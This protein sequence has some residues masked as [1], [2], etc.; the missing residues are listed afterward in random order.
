MFGKLRSFLGGGDSTRSQDPDG[1]EVVE[2]EPFPR[3]RL[4]AVPAVPAEEEDEIASA[5]GALVDLFESRE[6]APPLLDPA[7]R[8][9]HEAS[10]RPNVDFR[11]LAAMLSKDPV[12]A[13]ELL[14]T[15]NSP[16]YGGSGSVDSLERAL[17]R[18]GI[19]GIR[20]ILFSVAA[21]RVLRVPG[22]SWFT[23]RLRARSRAVAIAARILAESV[24]ADSE[25]AYTAGVLHDVGW[26]VAYDL[27]ARPGPAIPEAL[28]RDPRRA[29]Q[30]A[31]RTHQPLGAAL[32]RRWK[33]P[34]PVIH[35]LGAHHH[36]GD[37]PGDTSAR[38]VGGARGI[39]DF[40][41]FYPEQQLASPLESP[42]LGE[43]GLSPQEIAAAT[44]MMR[45]EMVEGEESWVQASSPGRR[46]S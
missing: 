32:G 25:S 39:C 45:T 4:L 38:L 5:S 1:G 21:G 14:R 12:V 3:G 42:A 37:G 20:N 34:E 13:M 35:A 10:S 26:A 30:I 27:L 8:D 2:V 19:E 36:P 33:L 9:A 7:S 31:A 22:K 17:G 41:G 11:V 40:L 24:G 15:A 28:S 6:A 46:A 43:L 23:R 29:M 18:L 16:R 44:R